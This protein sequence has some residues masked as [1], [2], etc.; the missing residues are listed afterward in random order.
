MPFPHPIQIVDH[1]YH[2]VI[3]NR[4]AAP[5]TGMASGMIFRGS[6]FRGRGRGQTGMKSAG[7][8]GY[9]R[10]IPGVPGKLAGDSP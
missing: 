5:G 2:A 4:V 9:P 3:Q 1:G 10:G 6:N 7:I 8:P